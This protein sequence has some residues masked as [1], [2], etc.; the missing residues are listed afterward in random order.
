DTDILDEDLKNWP[1]QDRIKYEEYLQFLFAQAIQ[2]GEI[3]PLV[4]KL[5]SIILNGILLAS[6][7]P[8]LV[9]GWEVEAGTAAREITDIIMQGIKIR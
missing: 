8:I 5:L 6:C 2:N 3:L 7:M 4:T 1:R 9:E